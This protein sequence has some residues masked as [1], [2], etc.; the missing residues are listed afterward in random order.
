MYADLFHGVSNVDVV[1]YLIDSVSTY[2][3]HHS[4]FLS[5]LEIMRHTFGNHNSEIG[6]RF[7]RSI[8]IL[9]HH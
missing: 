5:C 9:A 6:Y 8:A 1:Y 2:F 7:C 3:D 4:D